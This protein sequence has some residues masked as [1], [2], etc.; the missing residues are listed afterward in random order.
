MYL[1]S[2]TQ[3]FIVVKVLDPDMEKKPYW[4]K[5]NAISVVNPSLVRR[6]EDTGICS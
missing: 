6:L 1:F 3:H 4:E 5:T 2:P